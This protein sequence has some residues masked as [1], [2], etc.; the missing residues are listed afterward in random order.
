MKNLLSSWTRVM[1]SLLQD[2][3]LRNISFAYYSTLSLSWSVNTW[4]SERGSERASVF[5]AEDNPLSRLSASAMWIQIPGTGLRSYGWQQRSL[6]IDPPLWSPP[7]FL[8]ES[9]PEPGPRTQWLSYSGWPQR[10]GDLP[11]P[12]PKCQ[13]HK[14]TLFTVPS[15]LH[16]RL[17]PKALMPAWQ[18][19]Y[20]LSPLQLLNA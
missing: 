16:E 10:S 8:T 3:D 6:S 7:Y 11:T 12:P 18:A 20:W 4:V 19:L 14:Y 15:L 1:Q 13:D 9:L 5:K 17:G 2:Q